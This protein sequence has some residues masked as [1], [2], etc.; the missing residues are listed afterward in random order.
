MARMNG[1]EPHEAGW[2][3][4]LIYR[5]V[6]RKLG[7]LAGSSRLVEPVKI[8]AHHP[9]LL[10]ATGQMEL[11]LEAATAVDPALKSLAGLRAAMRIGCPF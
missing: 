1:V 10:W 6:R 9:R 7:K 3:T 8:A 5:P 11:G 2:L 4:R